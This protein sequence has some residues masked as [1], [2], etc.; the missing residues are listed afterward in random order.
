MFLARSKRDQRAFRHSSTLFSWSRLAIIFGGLGSRDEDKRSGPR[1]KKCARRRPPSDYS[2]FVSEAR[3]EEKTFF[4]FCSFISVLGYA[5][6]VSKDIPSSP[7]SLY[8]CI[9]DIRRPVNRHRET[10]IGSFF[11][12]LQFSFFFSFF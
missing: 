8:H 7:S 5:I 10:S 3:G 11:W 12:L 4:S 6:C 1:R 2:H 9:E